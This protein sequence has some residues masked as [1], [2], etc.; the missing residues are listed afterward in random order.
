MGWRENSLAGRHPWYSKINRGSVAASR[1]QNYEA[2]DRKGCGTETSNASVARLQA[3]TSSAKK[4]ITTPSVGMPIMVTE[5][6]ISIRG[7]M[8]ENLERR[9]SLTS[10]PEACS[11]SRVW[12]AEA[13]NPNPLY[14]SLNAFVCRPA[15]PTNGWSRS[16]DWFLSARRILGAALVDLATSVISDNVLPTAIPLLPPTPAR[17]T[18]VKAVAPIRHPDAAETMHR[19]MLVEKP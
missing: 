12:N 5:Q 18:S 3:T 16:P 8:P 17:A 14:S 2:K 15:A 11:S 13:E 4:T 10:N 19:K 7:C 1:T 6:N 9:A